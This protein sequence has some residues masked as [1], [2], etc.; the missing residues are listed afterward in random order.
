LKAPVTLEYKDGRIW[1]LKSPFHLKDEIK[2]MGGSRWHGFEV[3]PKKLWSV[4]D[5]F[6]NKFQLHYMMGE[7]VYE[8]FERPLITHDYQRPLMEHQKH[9]SD[10]GLTYHYQIWGAEMG[11]GKTLSAQEVIERANVPYWYWVGPKTSLPNIEREFIKWNWDPTTATIEYM[12]YE[13][14]V[15]LMDEYKEGNPIPNGVIFDES[16]RCK[17]PTSQRSLA[18][19]KLAHL[20]RTHY[21]WEGYV[22]EMSGTPSPKRP[23][24]WFSQCE[25]A[26]PGFLREGSIKALQNRL[27]FMVKHEFDSTTIWKPMGWRDDENKCQHCGLLFDEGPHDL[28]A[29]LCG[30][31]YHKYE[32]STNEVSYM[33]ERLKGLVVVKHKKDCMSLPDKRYRTIQCPPSDSLLRAAKTIVN[34]SPNAMTGMTLLRELSDGFQYRDVDDGTRRCNHCPNAAGKVDEWFNPEDDNRSYLD[35]SLLR[36]ELIAKLEKREIDCPKCHGTGEMKKIKRITRTIPCPKEKAL[37]GLLEE[38]EETGRILVFAGFTGSV[39]RCVEIC[40]KEGWDVVRCDG[41]G[42]QVTDCDGTIKTDVHALDYW[43]NLSGNARV[44]FVAHPESGGMSLTLTA[45]RMAVYWSNSFKPE[46]RV[47]SEDRI[48]RKGMDE[49][50]GCVIVDLIHL[51]TDAQ[52]VEVIRANRKLEL[53]TMGQLADVFTEVQDEEATP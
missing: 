18:A 3:P 23:T 43:E 53:M 4:D 20:I 21:N 12:T 38:C 41:R 40:H 34:A 30:E 5:S 25:I 33:F 13:R 35:I 8:W 6:R 52:V 24:D 51:P 32:P 49:N 10:S 48:H 7:N 28:E 17:T 22:I 39:D 50:L 2:A 26:W 45:S 44:A 16:S 47:Q 1:F 42:F 14:L 29:S 36:D 9:L 37:R 27:A 11:T 15:R 19:F 31:E 46:Y